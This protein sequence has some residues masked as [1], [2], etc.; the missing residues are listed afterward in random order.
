MKEERETYR[1]Y[2]MKEERET[3]RGYMSHVLK[4]PV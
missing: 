3:Y 2:T 4:D 1:G